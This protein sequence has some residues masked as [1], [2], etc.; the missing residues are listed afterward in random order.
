MSDEMV[1]DAFMTSNADGGGDAARQYMNI[2]GEDPE[3]VQDLSNMVVTNFMDEFM[4]HPVEFYSLGPGM[5]EFGKTG[6]GYDSDGAAQWIADHSDVI[7]I[8]PGLRQRLGNSDFIANE[9]MLDY[10]RNYS[11]LMDVE[12]SRLVKVLDNIASESETSPQELIDRAVRDPEMMKQIIRLIRNSERLATSGGRKP[13]TTEIEN[14]LTSLRRNIWY[15]AGDIQD[16]AQLTAFINDNIDSLR[17]LFTM[18][19]LSDLG[20]L[21]TGRQ[22]QANVP[23]PTGTAISPNPLKDV[24][25]R[26]GMALSTGASRIINVKSGRLSNTVVIVDALGRVVRGH[27]LLQSKALWKEALYNPK[28]AEALANLYRTSGAD[29][30]MARISDPQLIM[31]RSG[32][33]GVNRSYDRIPQNVLDSADLLRSRYVQLGLGLEDEEIER[34]DARDSVV[35][36][37]R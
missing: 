15:A 18:T 30:A 35:I 25:A 17:Q 28:V 29:N 10:N 20:T 13:Q 2:F 3:R 33:P 34:L 37:P 22:M 23:R 9:A 16:P 1:A 36:N 27:S 14:V 26:L 4:H 11:R 21:A 19:H 8:V 12:D 7:D 24:E 5:K 32:I 6:T 31:T